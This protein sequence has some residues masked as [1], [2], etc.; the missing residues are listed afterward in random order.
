MELVGAWH[1][2]YGVSLVLPRGESNELMFLLPAFVEILLG[3]IG[4]ALIRRTLLKTTGGLN[5]VA[6]LL[7]GAACV[8]HGAHAMLMSGVC[9]A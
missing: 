6:F 7:L 3:V 1:I 4:A 8:G 2:A 5:G 9:A